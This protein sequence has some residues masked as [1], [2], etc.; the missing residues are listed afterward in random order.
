MGTVDPA[1]MALI[2]GQLMSLALQHKDPNSSYPVNFAQEFEAW[3][4]D[5][6]P[7]R[8]DIPYFQT[9]D[10]EG[11]IQLWIVVTIDADYQVIGSKVYI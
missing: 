5:G 11:G 4:V 7:V 3:S 2:N 9:M 1:L 6:V 8:Y 10:P